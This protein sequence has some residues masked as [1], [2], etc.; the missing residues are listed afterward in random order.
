MGSVIRY[1]KTIISY[2]FNKE[3]YS[4]IGDIEGEIP[5]LSDVGSQACTASQFLEVE[6]DQLCKEINQE[7]KFHRKQWE[8]I[9]ILQVLRKYDLLKPGVKGLGFGCGKE[10][11]VA[12]MAK[13][14]CDVLATDINPLTGSDSHWG[15]N[16][17]LDLFYPGVC[18]EDDFVSR[19]NF[20]NVDMN[21]IPDDLVGFDFLWSCCALEHLGSLEHGIK[22]I[23]DANKCLKSGGVAIHTTEYNI[24]NEG[25]TLESPGLSLYRKSELVELERRAREQG[26]TVI[27][28]NWY[29]GDLPE[30]KYIDLPPYKQETHLKLMIEKFVLTSYGI[31]LIKG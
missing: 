12:V 30:D 17:V 22:F 6:Y 27:P 24:D 21:S 1:V 11:L 9:Y 28:F 4:R 13:Y 31:I 14:G 18:S 25:G 10:P 16:T 2:Y 29:T 7:K 5:T 19:V 26:D 23:L 15:A 8:Y 3:K 20:N